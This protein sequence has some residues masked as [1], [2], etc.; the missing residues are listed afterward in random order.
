M[1][2]Q[3]SGDFGI[4]SM[5]KYYPFFNNSSIV[6]MMFIISNFALSPKN[7]ID[8]KLTQNKI[9]NETL[10]GKQKHAKEV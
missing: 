4:E 6:I 10:C 5:E 9:M 3:V 7:F 8:E 2:M 1:G